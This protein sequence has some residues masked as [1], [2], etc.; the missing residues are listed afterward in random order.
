[1]PGGCAL[2]P[3]GR[4]RVQRGNGGGDGRR[5][6]GSDPLRDAALKDERMLHPIDRDSIESVVCEG[7][8][9][10][11]GRPPARRSAEWR[12]LIRRQAFMQRGI[13]RREAR[14]ER[15]LAPHRRHHAPAR[16]EGAIHLFYGRGPVR[17][18]LQ[19]LLAGD[20]VEALVI[21]VDWRGWRDQILDG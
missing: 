8:P 7:G 12:G 3:G 10:A 9:K 18:K 1:M 20:D 2:E 21:D 19:A 11:F 17:E 6:E 16:L 14:L 13:Q 5:G 4:L 15:D